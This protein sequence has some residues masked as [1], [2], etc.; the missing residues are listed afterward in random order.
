MG[1]PIEVLE[2]TQRFY[3]Q[4][5]YKS[6][7]RDYLHS[8]YLASA[9][10]QAGIGY[11][12]VGWTTT[13]DHLLSLGHQP[14]DLVRA[15][16]A[17]E[18]DHGLRDGMRDRL[19]LPVHDHTGQLVGFLG[20][21]NPDDSRSP[22]YLNTSA[23][24]LYQK[25]ATLYGLG[26]RSDDLAAGATPLIV[27]GPMDKLAVD[28]VTAKY[29]RDIV[30]LAT[31]GTSLTSE[32]IA[33]IRSIT[34]APVW[35]CFDADAAGQRAMLHAWTLT[36]DQG[37]ADQRVVRLPAGHDPASVHPRTLDHAIAHSVP[38]SVAVAEAQ[39]SLWG[40][41]DN[42]VRAELMLKAL[43]QRDAARV[44]PAD[45]AQWIIT[46]A[47]LTDLPVSNVQATLIEQ[48]APAPTSAHLTAVRA[49]SFPRS[50]TPSSGLSER[51]PRAT[52]TRVARPPARVELAR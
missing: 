46:V 42:Q 41:P 49:A 52:T 19:T 16:V 31:C 18:G 48:V 3:R 38:M 44:R 26:E 25:R 21:A 51:T 12:P 4:H 28:K 36:A 14:D 9:I 10:P 34:A 50:M 11:A 8:R 22:K 30:A 1:S 27:E 40:R 45:S 13:S 43:A 20:R 32:H 29:D 37:R 24:E 23:T 47:R 15:G 17:V 5:V 33:R 2:H 7:V 39:L 6:W 35:F